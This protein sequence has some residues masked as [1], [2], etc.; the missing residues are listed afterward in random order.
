MNLDEA[1]IKGLLSKIAPSKDLIEKELKETEYDIKS[2][3]ESLN[4]E[5][6]KW[7]IVKSY[8]AIFHCI[9]ALMFKHG[10]KDR[11][12]A[13]VVIFLEELEKQGIIDSSIVNDYRA[14]L[15]ARESADYRYTYSRDIAKNILQISKEVISKIRKLV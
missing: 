5:D 14:A 15:S 10:Y 7:C 11:K 9:R 2:A 6:Y 3:E 1:E 12:H 4:K 13:G 8:Y